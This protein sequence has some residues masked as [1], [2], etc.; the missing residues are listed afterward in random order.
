MGQRT[1]RK[2]KVK[3]EINKYIEVAKKILPDSDYRDGLING[4]ERAKII[5]NNPK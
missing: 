2:T 5:I 4:L 1:N 3:I